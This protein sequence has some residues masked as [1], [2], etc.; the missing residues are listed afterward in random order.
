MEINMS[1]TLK[2][3]TTVKISPFT[4][5]DNGKVRTGMISPAFP[6]VR[7]EP[8]NVGDGGKVRIGMISPAF[9]PVRS[10]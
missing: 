5:K 6:P 3:V 2:E 1:A 4:I 10:R 7:A 8:E 9:P